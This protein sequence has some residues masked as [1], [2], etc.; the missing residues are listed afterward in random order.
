[1]ISETPLLTAL[2][3]RYITTILFS[4]IALNCVSY[5]GLLLFPNITRFMWDFRDFFL[6][7]FY[8][9]PPVCFWPVGRQ[10]FFFTI[11]SDKWHVLTAWLYHTLHVYF[12]FPSQS[13][14]DVFESVF[15]SGSDKQRQAFLNNIR[16]HVRLHNVFSIFKVKSN[17]KLSF[18]FS[19]HLFYFVLCSYHKMTS[20]YHCLPNGKVI[21]CYK[22]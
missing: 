8:L 19:N 20:S 4:H 7:E 22:Q 5:L 17:T 6:L 10:W 1:M 9:N 12:D 21:L 14:G 2:M 16:Q 15:H 13:I 18:V 3:I 11:L